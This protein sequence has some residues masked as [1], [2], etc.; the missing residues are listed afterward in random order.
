[1]TT[2]PDEETADRVLDGLLEQRLAACIQTLPI[3]SAYRWKGTVNRDP[4]IL[5]LIKTRTALYPEVEA[6]L[7]DRHPYE[8]PEI[9][10]LPAAAGA[11]AYLNWID[12]ETRPPE[13][14]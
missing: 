9:L 12:A 2:F 7:K 11:L 5:A 3:R 14:G 4:E 10:L 13:S 8:N 6:F 1:M